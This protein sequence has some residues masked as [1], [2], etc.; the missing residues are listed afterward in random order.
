MC[1]QPYS[2]G[3][4]WWGLID[5]CLLRALQ[6]D[7][8]VLV[9][10]RSDC[11]VCRVVFRAKKENVLSDLSALSMELENKSQTIC[12][13]CG[14]PGV[15]KTTDYNWVLTSC[16]RC[17]SMSITDRRKVAAKVKDEYFHGSYLRHNS[18]ASRDQIR[19]KYLNDF[20][21]W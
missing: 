11:G 20:I 4:G 1:K 2:T 10:A 7:P 14:E 18:F 5:E 16:E 9:E 6:I 13:N 19:G 12:E 3:P 15:R 21:K 8:E 17:F